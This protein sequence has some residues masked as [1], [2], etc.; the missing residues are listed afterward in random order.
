MPC[1]ILSV[2]QAKRNPCQQVAVGEGGGEGWVW[3]GGLRSEGCLGLSEA[4]GDLGVSPG[5]TV[6][7]FQDVSLRRSLS[8][9]DTVNRQWARFPVKGLPSGW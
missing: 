1:F 8:F 5:L 6:L 4:L 9:K 7:I 3:A 2:C